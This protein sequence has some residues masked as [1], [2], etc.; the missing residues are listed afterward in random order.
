MISHQ[1]WQTLSALLQRRT[2]ALT[3]AVSE[4]LE[5]DPSVE[6]EELDTAWREALRAQRTSFEALLRDGVITE[7]TFAHLIGEVDLALTDPESNWLTYTR[8][9][10]VPPISLLMTAFLQEQD[11]E[12]AINALNKQGFSITRLS[13]TG[14]L[15]ENK[16]ATL[17]IGI[18]GNQEQTALQVI[19][20]CSHQRT[21]AAHP[22]TGNIPADIARATIFT[23]DVERYEELI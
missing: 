13:S 10:Q 8:G 15:L 20:S 12:N 17:L 4:V 11:A 5:I 3:E 18:P 23:F 1:T 21:G 14:G 19:E 22:L 16:I 7:D 9:P 6:A 2:R